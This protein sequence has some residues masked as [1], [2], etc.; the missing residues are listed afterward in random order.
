MKCFG[1]PSNWSIAFFNKASWVWIRLRRRQ[2]SFQPHSLSD[3]IQTEDPLSRLP[4]CHAHDTTSHSQFFKH[5]PTFTLLVIC[6]QSFVWLE[7]L[8]TIFTAQKALTLPLRFNSVICKVKMNNDMPFQGLSHP[9]HQWYMNLRSISNSL[10]SLN[11]EA[12]P[13][14]LR[15][16]SS[17]SSELPSH[18][19]VEYWTYQIII[20]CLFISLSFQVEWVQLEGRVTSYLIF[21]LC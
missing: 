15:H 8:F 21:T 20:R 11:H 4:A 6:S 16:N 19:L 13:D 5:M 2:Q 18:M 1:S 9:I 17:G 3:A 10:P 7:C 14:A 12:I